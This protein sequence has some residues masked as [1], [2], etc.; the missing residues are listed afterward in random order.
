[1]ETASPIGK[2]FCAIASFIIHIWRV[3]IEI[4]VVAVLMSPSTV[5]DAQHTIRIAGIV[6]LFGNGAFVSQDAISL[7]R[8]NGNKN[9]FSVFY[10]FD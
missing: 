3:L 6:W 9:A 5:L 2:I 8:H 7:T 1:M 4:L 10:Q